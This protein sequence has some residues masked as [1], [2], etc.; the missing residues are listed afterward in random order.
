MKFIDEESPSEDRFTAMKTLFL[1]SVSDDISEEER[2]LSH[3]FMQICKQLESSD[4]LIIKA[5]FDI[6]EGKLKNKLESTKIDSNDRSA[7][8]WLQNIAKQIG[9]GILSLIEVQEEKLINLKLISPRTHSDSSGILNISNYRLTDLGCK[10]CEFIN[11][12]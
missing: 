12:P 9:H 11:E 10:L 5:A 1:R 2:I 6:K 7:Q 8:G 3:Q 4:L